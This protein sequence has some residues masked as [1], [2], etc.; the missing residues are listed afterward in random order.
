MI[1]LLIQTYLKF[2][3]TIIFPAIV[4]FLAIDVGF[5]IIKNLI[6]SRNGY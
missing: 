6:Q 5:V 1:D 4:V 2:W 3:A